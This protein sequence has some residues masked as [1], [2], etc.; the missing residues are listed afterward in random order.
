MVELITEKRGYMAEMRMKNARYPEQL[1]RMERL[2][3]LGLCYFCREGNEA[4]VTT[5]TILKEWNHWYV[6]QN[7][8]PQEGS[9]HHYLMVSKRHITRETELE[10]L[11][12]I[13][14]QE[15]MK[16]LENEVKSPGFSKFSRNGNLAYTGATLD[17]LHVHFLV[18][19]KD[20]EGAEKIKVSLGYKEPQ[21]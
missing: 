7:N 9:T 10:L 8:F 21:S 2:K 12:W 16:W 17:H 15:V 3:E 18:G 6:T 14:L 11:E 20:K 5:P 19:I 4:D 1:R 13:Q